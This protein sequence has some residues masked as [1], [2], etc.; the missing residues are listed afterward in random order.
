ML[1][2][3]SA[4]VLTFQIDSQLKPREGVWIY[5]ADAGLA[6]EDTCA[7]MH[8]AKKYTCAFSHSLCSTS[9]RPMQSRQ[10]PCCVRAMARRLN[11]SL[12]SCNL[13]A[14]H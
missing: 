6:I 9:M 10:G 7:N 1:N 13:P 2:T 5:A 4:I 12:V 8:C 11:D 14:V 3:G